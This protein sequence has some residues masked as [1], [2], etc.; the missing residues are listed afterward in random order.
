MKL[1]FI[2]K[3]NIILLLFLLVISLA[4]HYKG[5]VVLFSISYNKVLFLILFFIYMK[6]IGINKKA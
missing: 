3:N 4:L 1:I 2:K 5:E 6:S